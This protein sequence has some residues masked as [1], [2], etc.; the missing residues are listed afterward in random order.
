MELPLIY[1]FVFIQG[2]CIG[3][4]LYDVNLV[5]PACI[6]QVYALDNEE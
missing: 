1:I 6:Q 4:L 2:N 3:N 5:Y